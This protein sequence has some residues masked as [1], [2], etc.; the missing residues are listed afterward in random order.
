MYLFDI[1]KYEVHW[2]RF[3]T[4]SIPDSDLST[5]SDTEFNIRLEKELI[6]YNAV[7]IPDDEFHIYFMS[8]EDAAMFIL[9]FS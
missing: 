9:K 8:E 5:L 6:P 2:I 3:I 1:R 4:Q 7:D